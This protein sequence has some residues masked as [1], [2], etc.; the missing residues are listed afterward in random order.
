MA[1]L[2][3][4]RV[5]TVVNIGEAKTHLSDLVA[6]AERGE[7]VVLARAGMPIVRLAPVEPR[8]PRFGTVPGHIPDSFFEPLPE[9]EL[10]A[11]E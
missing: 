7:D 10:E 11:W 5:T 6:R 2:S 8:R 1:N 9:D 3:V 4:D